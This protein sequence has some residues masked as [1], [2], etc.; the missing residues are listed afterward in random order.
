[1]PYQD[2][3]LQRYRLGVAR[4]IYQLGLFEW[5]AITT[6]ISVQLHLHSDLRRTRGQTH[7]L[8]KEVTIIDADTRD[9]SGTIGIRGIK[10]LQKF[11]AGKWRKALSRKQK[12]LEMAGSQWKLPSTIHR[13]VVIHR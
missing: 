4:G 7:L 1:M 11:C 8:S 2:L 12:G 5:D 3:S 10:W 13:D 6:C 9:E